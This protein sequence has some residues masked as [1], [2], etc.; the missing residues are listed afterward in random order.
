MTRFAVRP[1]F[2]TVCWLTLSTMSTL[3]SSVHAGGSYSV[4]LENDF[5]TGSDNN[6]TNGVGL[7]WA[8]NE[9]SQYPTDSAVQRWYRFW[10]FLPGVDAGEAKRHVSWTLGQE[11][12]TPDD[13]GDP[14]PP[15]DDQPYAGVAYIDS[16]IH[17]LSG[18]WS[19]SW[20]LRVGVVGPASGAG[21]VQRWVH[22]HL[23]LDPPQGWNTQLS[24]EP[25]LNIGITRTYRFYEKQVASRFK[26]RVVPGFNLEAGNYQTSAS[27]GGLVEFGRNLPDALAVSSLGNGLDTSGVVGGRPNRQ[28]SWSIFLAL[29][30]HLYAHYLPLDGTVFRNS[31]SVDRDSVVGFAIV[32]AS[33]RRGRFAFNVAATRLSKTFATQRNDVSFG[34]MSVAWYY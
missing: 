26:L 32:G 29:G 2:G 27:A 5:V 4:L 8:S 3:C 17:T 30:G 6:Y 12:H 24:N 18:R 23:S 33:L 20:H 34:I 22:R 14:N 10:S 13:I 25:L 11:M 9:L 7:S 1:S 19:Q 28:L 16:D 15:P 31:R 21:K